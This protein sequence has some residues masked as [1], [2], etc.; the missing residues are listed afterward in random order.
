MTKR[1]EI[2]LP[3][4]KEQLVEKA[5]RL[6]SWSLASQISILIVLGLVMGTSQAMKAMWLEDILSIVPTTAVLIGIYVSKWQPDENFNYGY[7]R[8]VQIGCLAGAVALLGFGVFLFGD[9]LLKLVMV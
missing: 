6:E 3:P 4:D 2:H 8:S 7:R 9:S 1:G 5:K